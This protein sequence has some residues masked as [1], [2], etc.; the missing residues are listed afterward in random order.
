MVA[1]T[2]DPGWHVY[3]MEEPQ[4]GPIATQVGLAENDPAETL[5]VT[6]SKPQIAPD[7]SFGMSTGVFESS[8]DFTLYLRAVPAPNA[9]DGL[10]VLIRYQACNDQVCLPPHTDTVP[11]PLAMSR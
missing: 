5:R 4:G 11:V 2:I 7:A 9:G 8:V 10:Q 6:S 3:A 1:G